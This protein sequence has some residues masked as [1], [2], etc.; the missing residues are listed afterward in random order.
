MVVPRGSGFGGSSTHVPSQAPDSLQA[1]S[2]ATVVD[3]YSEGECVGL[4]D[5]N[6]NPIVD[7]KLYGKG[8]F[9]NK[10]PLMSDDGHVNF[11]NV[12]VSQVFGTQSQSYLP[13]ASIVSNTIPDGREL[14][15]NVAKTIAIAVGEN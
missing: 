6:W 9:L 2:F 10:T 8:I 13:G 11:E 15:Y 1:L 3:A 5:R 14:R 7:P 12:Y 4:C